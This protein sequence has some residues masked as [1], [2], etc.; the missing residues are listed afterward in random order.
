MRL[1]QI[2]PMVVMKAWKIQKIMNETHEK[3]EE[4]PLLCSIIHMKLED[5]EVSPAAPPFPSW[6]RSGGS[7]AD[8]G[9][10]VSGWMGLR[11]SL[12]AQYGGAQRRWRR[13]DF[14][15]DLQVG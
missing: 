15:R 1:I 11:R 5:R 9:R 6:R 8:T 4:V 13:E 10:R 3:R 2:M 14:G 12:Q 7:S